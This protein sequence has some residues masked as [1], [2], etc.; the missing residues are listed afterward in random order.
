MAGNFA[1]LRP[2]TGASICGLPVWR[3]L[4]SRISHM[5]TQD[6]MSRCYSKQGGSHIASKTTSVSHSITSFVDVGCVYPRLSRRFLVWKTG[7]VTART[8]QG[9]DRDSGLSMVSSALERECRTFAVFA[10][11]A[12][13]GGWVVSRTSLSSSAL[14]IHLWSQS[15]RI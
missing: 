9:G 12:M 1:Q 13:L 11:P 4:G 5:A 8:L 2:K 6:S 10:S 14:N 15:H 7:S 3:P